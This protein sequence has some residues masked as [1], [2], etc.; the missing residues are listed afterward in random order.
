MDR[1][2]AATVYFSHPGE[3]YAVGNIEIGNTRRVAE[4]ISAAA[5]GRIFEIA[6][7]KDYAIPYGELTK[8]A[9]EEQRRGELPPY[10]G[11]CD[12]SS[13]RLVFI[14]GPVWW[15]TWPQVVF[16][17]LRDHDLNGK[18]L[19]PFTTHEGSGL[20][21][22][23]RDLKRLFPSAK[24]LPGLAVYGHEAAQSGDRA[25]EFARRALASL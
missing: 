19:A 9:M 22:V 21:R 14:G 6:C 2:S 17:F 18:I 15:G 8:L 24:V 20:G 11:Q 7:A 16:T 23:E 5:G 10:E 25:A 1:E 3:N 4:A 13:A 12:L